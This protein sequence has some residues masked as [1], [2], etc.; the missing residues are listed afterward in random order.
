MHELLAELRG[1]YETIVIDAPPL[2]SVT[3]AALLAAQTDGEVM[4]VRQVFAGPVPGPARSRESPPTQPVAAHDGVERIG[5]ASQA[6]ER[7]VVRR[8]GEPAHDLVRCASVGGVG[9]DTM[10]ELRPSQSVRVFRRA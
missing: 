6:T 8:V 1:T 4:V 9:T 2:M 5:I 3:D 10:C 7:A